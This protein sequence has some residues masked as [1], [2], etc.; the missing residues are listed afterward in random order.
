[1]GLYR[2]LLRP[3]LFRVDAEAMHGL[4]IRAGEL[5]SAAP[6]LCV[7]LA[8][9]QHARLDARLAID[10]AGLHFAT[11]LG[12]AA[13]FDKSARAV[14][15]LGAL[16][17]GH[18]EVGSVSAEPSAGNAKPRLFRLP[19]DRAIVV[20]YGLPNDG[21]ERVAR[22]LDGVPRAVPLGINV[23]S[24]N[25]GAGAPPAS[26]EAVIADYLQ[27]VHRL[28]A[29]ADYLCLNLS[30]PNTRDG[31]N[32]FHEP[33]RLR[34]LLEGLDALGLGKPV[35]LKVAP[36]AALADLE[37]FLVTVEPARCVSGFSVNLRAGKPAGM[38]TPASRLAQLPGAV[39]GAPAAAAAERTLAELYARMDRRR[40]RLV[41]SGGVFSAADAYR[42]IRLGASLVQLL[43]A[44][45]YEGP[46]VVASINRGLARLLQTD[47]IT[48]VADAVGAGVSSASTKSNEET[49]G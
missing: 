15:L 49:A 34:S 9:R 3:L 42:Q 22:R 40:Y 6:R 21:A 11:P 16:G 13:G 44:L 1:M 46:G 28:Q 48:R 26:D 2:S 27:A 47:G 31:R 5:A 25:R 19:E 37:S 17:F 20:N 4:A 36:F 35:F 32:F 8:E 14:P 12:L 38:A 10:V 29:S 7:A 23:V 45:V 18:V 30:C 41:G 39:S 33:H 43:T 24:T